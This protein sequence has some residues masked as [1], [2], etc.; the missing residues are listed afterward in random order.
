MTTLLSI[1]GRIADDHAQQLSLLDRGF[2][3]GDGIFETLRI[4]NGVAFKQKEH[5][6]RLTESAGRLGFAL[7][8]DI[9]RLVSD[10]SERGLKAGLDSAYFRITLSRGSSIGLAVESQEEATVCTVLTPLPAAQPGHRSGIDVVTADGRR[11]EFAQSAGLKT[12][13]Y[14][15][16]IL[17]LRNARQASAGDAIFLDTQ[18]HISEATASN[19]FVCFKGK[20]FTPP[21]KCGALP[22]ITRATVLGIARDD[23]IEVEDDS[24]LSPEF[25]LEASEVFLT[26]SVR[27]IVPVISVD[28][29]KVGSGTVGPL[30]EKIVNLYSELTQCR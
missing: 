8:L 10:E 11:N 7:N 1:N 28:G 19:L 26:S 21:L 27:E 18:G 3:L 5:V 12:T 22:G 13:A 24:F 6:D 25:L 17:A 30:T 16:S 29:N 15:D 9:N 23:G 4:Y 14:M 20:V 2:L